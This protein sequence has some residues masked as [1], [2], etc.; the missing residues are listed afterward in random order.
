M[1]IAKITI[2]ID[3]NLLNQLDRL[4]QAHI[5]ASRSQ[6]VQAAVQEKITRLNKTRLAQA[7]AQ[8]DPLA[9]QALADEGLTAEISAWPE[10]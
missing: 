8:L 4:V 7:C 5:F 1:N 10:Y 9:E 2:S 6:A 3:Q